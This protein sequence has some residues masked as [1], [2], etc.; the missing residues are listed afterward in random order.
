MNTASTLLLLL[1]FDRSTYQPK[2]IAIDQGFQTIVNVRLIR[3]RT[4]WSIPEGWGDE[5][6]D[7]Q[8]IFNSISPVTGKRDPLNRH[9]PSSSRNLRFSYSRTALFT[10]LVIALTQKIF[11]HEKPRTVPKNQKIAP[12]ITRRR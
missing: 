10:G 4:L 12:Y 5:S 7:R 11:G 1:A 6:I 8:A 9:Y 2:E 3:V